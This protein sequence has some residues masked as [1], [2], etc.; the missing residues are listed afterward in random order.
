MGFKQH[1][2]E[3]SGST[4]VFTYGRMNPPTQ[5][6]AKV[7]QK[8]IDHA[9]KIG[10]VPHV[11]ISHSHDSKKNPL[12]P[13]HKLAAVQAAFKGVN[14]AVSTKEMS[15]P[16]QLA[17]HLNQQ[18]HEHLVM[19]AGSDRVN[20]Y[21]AL[22]HKY[23]N[24][25]YSFK[26]IKVV[27]AGQRDPDAEGA[28]GISGTKMREFA[29][30]GKK[31]EF[32]SNLMSGLDDDHK[33]RIYTATRTGMKIDEESPVQFDWG[34]PEGTKYMKKLT[35]GETAPKPNKSLREQYFANQIY[36]LGDLVT[37]NEGVTGH[38]VY[39]GTNYVTICNTDNDISKHWLDSIVESNSDEVTPET[40]TP[41]TKKTVGSFKDLTKKKEAEKEVK[42]TVDKKEVSVNETV[43]DAVAMVRSFKDLKSAAEL[44]ALFMSPDQ[45]AQAAAER[46][47]SKQISFDGYTTQNFHLC[48]AAVIRFNKL[49]ADKFSLAASAPEKPLSVKGWSTYT[50]R[51]YHHK[52]ID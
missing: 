9:T 23:N 36:R 3:A 46:A 43:I 41:A 42:V 35:P 15:G 5:G 32:K 8:T 19:V 1:I 38:I 40:T 29:A 39:R 22:L 2:Q 11:F 25:E 7:I 48:P 21:H 37:T 18:G 34:T 50:K 12:A 10:G 4:A 6:H 27:S 13:E 31:D 14:A 20:E 17:K 44:P 33:E 26:S 24:K 51:Q 45:Q 30:A 49:I 28:A 47:G 52:V 16:I